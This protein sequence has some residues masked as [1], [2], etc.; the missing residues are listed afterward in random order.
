MLGLTKRE[1]GEMK[2]RNRQ[3]RLWF[4]DFWANYVR[5]HPDEDWSRQQNVL[6]NSVYGETAR[7]NRQLLNK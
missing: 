2:E 1:I 4:V 7:K 6:M 3:D 5:T